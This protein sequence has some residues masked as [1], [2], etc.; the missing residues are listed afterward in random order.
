MCICVC[1]HAR[2]HVQVTGVYNNLC[3]RMC[4]VCAR[5]RCALDSTTS[6]LPAPAPIAG[7]SRRTSPGRRWSP[8]NPGQG[9]ACRCWSWVSCRLCETMARRSGPTSVIMAC[10]S[11]VTANCTWAIEPVLPC[12][13]VCACA[14]KRAPIRVCCVLLLVK[15]QSP[16]SEASESPPVAARKWN[17][18]VWKG[19]E[20]M[21]W[22]E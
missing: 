6:R 17:T 8:P 18:C 15:T 5:L 16:D 12:V 2:V 13:P 9:T 3:M 11:A 20:L 4:V 14:Y 1:V 21:V 10:R 19:G 22:C 7:T